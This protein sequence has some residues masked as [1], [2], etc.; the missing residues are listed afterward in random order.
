MAFLRKGFLKSAHRRNELRAGIDLSVAA[1]I[2][3]LLLVVF[4]VLPQPERAV[5][6]DFVVAHHIHYLTGAIRDDAIKISL[7]R[8]GTVYFGNSLVH[9][10]DLPSLIRDAVRNGSEK[11]IY[12]E[13]DARARYGDLNALL[14]Q[15]QRSGI[16]NV[17]I[18]AYSPRPAAPPS[19]LPTP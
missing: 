4:M 8:Y 1:I 3:F 19:S 16:E 14:P 2:S 13:V 7:T 17:S 15:I 5:H 11:R 12:L 6:I 10:D 18:L 9:C